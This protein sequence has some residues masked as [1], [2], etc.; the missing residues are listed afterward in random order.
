MAISYFVALPFV[1]ADDRTIVACASAG[2]RLRQQR[3]LNRLREEPHPI[4]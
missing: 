4:A 1:L 2:C 3:A